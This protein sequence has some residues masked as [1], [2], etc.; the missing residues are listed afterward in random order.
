MQ[1]L[2]GHRSGSNV[3]ALSFAPDGASLASCTSA[4]GLRV[5]DLATGTARQPPR[6]GGWVWDVAFAPARR[7]VAYADLS[8][9]SLWGLDGPPRRL[10]RG[11]RLRVAFGPDGTWLAGALTDVVRWEVASGERQRLYAAPALSVTTALAVSPDGARLASAHKTDNYGSAASPFVRLAGLTGEGACLPEGAGA[12]VTSL[13]FRPDGAALAAASG[14]FL[15]VWEVPSGRPL[16]RL[17]LG[18]T[19]FQALAFSPD[20]RFLAAVRNDATVHFWDARSFREVAAFDWQIGPLVSLAF[21]PD[22]MRAAA[23]SKKGL[24]VVWDVDL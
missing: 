13:A 14:T 24:I 5:W 9:V 21:A 18:A 16:A 11:R 17:K 19:F 22:G 10:V 7:E 23:G 4:D 20:G 3:A 2:S 12:P 6:G 1:V 8:G 15:L